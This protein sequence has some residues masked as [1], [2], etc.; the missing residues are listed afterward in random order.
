MLV[1]GGAGFIGSHFVHHVLKTSPHITI[2]NVDKLTYAGSLTH[3]K[4]LNAESRH[5]F[6]QAD[7]NDEQKMQNIFREF[8]I[9][10]VVHFAA[11]SHV[12]RSITSPLAFIE[13]NVKGTYV[14][15]ETAKQYWLGQKKLM[16]MQCRFHH[17]STDEVYG[18]LHEGDQPFTESS[19]HRPRSP[20]SA[21][22]ASA[23]HLVN[24]YYHTF[25]LPITISH[26]SNNF[27]PH[28]DQEKFIPT[29]IL[30]CMLEKTIPIYGQ[31][32]QIR[33]WLYVEDHCRGVLQIIQQGAVGESYGMGGGNE[34]ENLKLAHY[35]CE[36][37]DH[38]IPRKYAHATL[39]QNVSDRPGHDFRY[40][41]NTQKICTT[42]GWQPTIDFSHGLDL[43]ID[44]Y[45]Q[46]RKATPMHQAS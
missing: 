37:M 41:I 42:I 39:I 45:Q 2:I 40:A 26:C 4:N 7:I 9:D 33:D 23:D 11:E 28:Q 32:K 24:A 8:D 38:V 46:Q 36:K 5:I 35:I 34:W 21:S 14:L 17:I 27:G 30:S 29:I 19:P 43:T 3:L 6:I 16:P 25:G 15:L 22:K 31:G 10:T 1:T 13:T 20:Y 44:Y 12:D 18:A